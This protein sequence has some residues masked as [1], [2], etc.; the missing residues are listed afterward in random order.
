[1][2]PFIRVGL[3]A[4]TAVAFSMCSNDASAQPG[5]P[6]AAG[7]T[8]AGDR[9]P[10]DAQYLAATTPNVVATSDADA[11]ATGKVIAYGRV[12]APPYR[13]DIDGDRLLV[14][15]IR[16]ERPLTPP[17]TSWPKIVV[18]DH[19]RE[20]SKLTKR[21]RAEFRRLTTETGVRRPDLDLLAYIAA[22]EPLVEN[23]R[24]IASDHLSLEFDG[25]EFLALRFAAV[26]SAAELAKIRG[27]FLK[28]KR[29]QYRAALGRG[30]LLI[31]GNSAVLTVPKE[32]IAETE[33]A[34][35]DALASGSTKDL[36]RALNSERL[37]RE[38]QF[39]E[40]KKLNPKEKK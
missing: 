33:R 5:S 38:R 37:A 40:S 12:I 16:V 39:A 17:W 20:I 9:V 10:T 28:S 26:P 30:S 31:L 21:I 34:I 6:P 1:M 3:A 35:D 22:N 15:G 36:A 32:R 25:G 29:A 4:I 8:S 23:A 27:G 7:D 19:H 13:V 2:F 14:N 11:I 18:T 24:W